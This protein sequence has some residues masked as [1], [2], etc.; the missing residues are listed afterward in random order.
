V[1]KPLTTSA[2]LTVATG[3]SGSSW[4]FSGNPGSTYEFRVRAHDYAGNVQPW[5][6]GYSVQAQMSP[7]QRITRMYIPL[8]LR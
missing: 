5:Y 3:L 7:D 8:L 2:W 4:V 6:D 1:Y